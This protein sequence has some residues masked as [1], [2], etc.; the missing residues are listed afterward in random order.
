MQGFGQPCARRPAAQ[1]PLK[2]VNQVYVIA[3]STKVDMSGVEADHLED[4]YFKAAE[5]PRG[6]K[7]GEEDFF[8]AEAEDKPKVG[9]DSCGRE[10]LPL[11]WKMLLQADWVRWGPFS[12]PRAEVK[13][14]LGLSLLIAA[15]AS[16][17]KYLGGL[18][19][20]RGGHSWGHISD[21]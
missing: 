5:K 12:R 2:R 17:G 16:L 18:S 9:L 6:E 11:D 13:P 21:P 10:L 19:M 4:G 7:K 8:K 3:T 14:K 20:C 15:A 1:V